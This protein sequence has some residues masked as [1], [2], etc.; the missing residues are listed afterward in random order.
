MYKYND[1]TNKKSNKTREKNS[2]CDANL[3]NKNHNTC[4]HKI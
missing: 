4:F 2:P 3:N 1:K